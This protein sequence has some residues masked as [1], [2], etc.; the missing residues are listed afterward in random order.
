[1]MSKISLIRQV[2]LKK[3]TVAALHLSKLIGD[4]S[5]PTHSC[6]IFKLEILHH[7]LLIFNETYPSAIAYFF[8]LV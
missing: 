2:Q 5:L 3:G 6:C 4:C 8:L 7:L 1:M